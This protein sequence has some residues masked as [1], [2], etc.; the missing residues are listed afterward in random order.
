MNLE[1]HMAK[2]EDVNSDGKMRILWKAEKGKLMMEKCIRLML[3]TLTKTQ[4]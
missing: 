3:A 4:K 1:N 2:N